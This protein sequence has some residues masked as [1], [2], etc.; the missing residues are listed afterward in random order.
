MFTSL[1]FR[2]RF[3]TSD[4]DGDGSEY[5][6]LGEDEIAELRGNLLD[7]VLVDFVE[8][9]GVSKILVKYL[10]EV[11]TTRRRAETTLKHIFPKLEEKGYLESDY[12]D[13]L[14]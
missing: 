9:M 3:T 2:L 7:G 8:R 4:Y 11:G 6:A 14:Y 10:T 12:L 5:K 13:E 1:A